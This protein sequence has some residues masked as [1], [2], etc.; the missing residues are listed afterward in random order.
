LPDPL[1]PEPEPE[2]PDPE[3]LLPDPDP[4][5]PDPDPLLPDPDPLLPDP[6]PLLPD[7]DPLLPDPEPLLPDPDPLFPDPDPL[8]PDPEPLLPD[9]DPMLPEPAPPFPPPEFGPFGSSGFVP[10]TAG[11]SVNDFVCTTPV[12]RTPP[13]AVRTLTISP[14][15]NTGSTPPS[16]VLISNSPPRIGGGPTVIFP[17]ALSPTN[18]ST[19]VPTGRFNFSISMLNF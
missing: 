3:P 19:T 1:L 7:P 17:I 4:L 15:P 13:A 12:S 16:R 9:P 5:L 11:T 2:P 6:D 14:A 10:G 8:F 18:T